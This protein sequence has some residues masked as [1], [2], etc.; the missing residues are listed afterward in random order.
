MSGRERA[1]MCRYNRHTSP[2]SG[3]ASDGGGRVEKVLVT[4]CPS[5][6]REVPLAD[7]QLYDVSVVHFDSDGTDR[8][9]I[10]DRESQALLHVCRGVMGTVR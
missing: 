8:T 2:W 10:T 5:C 7:G 4:R 6:S 3:V 1:P 9:T